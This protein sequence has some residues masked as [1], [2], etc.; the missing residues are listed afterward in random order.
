[1]VGYP[2]NMKGRLVNRLLGDPEGI[3]G[4]PLGGHIA[5]LKFKKHLEKDTG[6]REAFERQLK[7]EQERRRAQREASFPFQ[8][9]GIA[10]SNVQARVVPETAK[11]LVEYFLY[12]EAHEL[13]IEIS[14]LRPWWEVEDRLIELEALQKVLLEGTEAYDKMQADFLMAKQGLMKIL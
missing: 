6:A 5:R 12:T 11:G 10:V 2:P 3:L 13:E 9:G 1:M 7:E 4:P 14:R 8:F